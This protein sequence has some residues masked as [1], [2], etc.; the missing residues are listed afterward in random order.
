[1]TV[2]TEIKKRGTYLGYFIV[3]EKLVNGKDGLRSHQ[4][5]LF[6]EA[7]G[8]KRRDY[9]AM[10]DIVYGMY[11][12]ESLKKIGKAGGKNGWAGRVGTYASD[13]AREPTNAKILRVMDEE[14]EAGTTIEVY[15]FSVPKAQSEYFCTI[16]NE[17]LH[18][19]VEQ[20]GN[21]EEHLTSEALE[22][23]EDLIFCT[24]LK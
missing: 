8:M 17:T 16:T 5:L 13:P 11:V 14:F 24:Q 10:G 6:T 1:M 20:H 21:V 4:A 3:G 23:G 15:G 12:A 19:E 2:S 22:E 9:I 7:P 18:F